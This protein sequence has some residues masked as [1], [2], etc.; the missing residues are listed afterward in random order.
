M[1]F[2]KLIVH[3]LALSTSK[4]AQNL[5]WVFAGN[6]FLIVLTFFATILVANSV[7]KA[8]NGI[9]LAL[10]TLANLLSELGEAGLGSSLSSFI[11]GLLLIPSSQNQREARTYL[12]TAFKLEVFISLILGFGVLVLSFPLSRWI[13]A[14]TN[15]VHVIFTG[16]ITSVLVLFGFSNFALSAYKKFREVAMMNIFYSVIRLVLLVLFAFLFKLSVL[17]ILIIYLLS[18]GFG[19]IISIMLI[20][21]QFIFEKASKAHALKLIKFSSLLA[22]QKIFISISSRL[23]LLMLVPLSS[24]V[25]AGIY[26]IAQRFVLIYPVIIGSL[27]QVLAPQFAE[28]AKGHQAMQ[29]FKKTGIVITLLLI[30]ELLFYIFAEPLMSLLVPKYQES[31]PV[32]RGLLI[33][34][35][36]FIIATPFTSFLIYT[37]KKT[38]VTTFASFIQLF[39]IFLFNIYFI[40]KYG[41]FAPAIGIGIGNV[42]SC[43]IVIGASVYYLGKES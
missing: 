30:S 1:M 8:D 20:N 12:S 37:L 11:P 33:A 16:L 32:F 43:L 40:P 29:F 18:F 31:I 4:T 13:F 17:S 9:F 35:T 27:G 23:D 39:I 15:P 34:I 7:S 26:G 36:G 5:Y 21:K 25:E 2:R 14:G 38:H 10:L 28:F 24:A 19:W 22:I 3:G 6:G 41:R 42:V